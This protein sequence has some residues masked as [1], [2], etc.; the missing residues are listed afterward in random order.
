MSFF[1]LSIRRP[2]RSNRTFTL[3][4]YTTLCLSVPLVAVRLAVRATGFY[5]RSPV[6]VYYIGTGTKN[7][8]E[9]DSKGAR[10]AIGW[11]PSDR[12]T[13]DLVGQIQDTDTKGLALQDNVTG[14]FTPLYGKRKYSQFFDALSTNRY[15][16][17]SATGTYDV[18]IGR[19]IAVAAY[20]ESKLHTE[21]DFSATYVPLLPLFSLLGYNYPANTGFTYQST[22]PQK[23]KRSE[24]HTSELQSLMRISYAYFCLKKKTQT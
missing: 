10:L 3:F 6:F 18:G 13:I 20:S 22:I 9:S 2:P 15:R 8:N 19:V 11:T 17:L 23:K 1:F 21:N 12:V 24:E 7:D 14:T 5:R 16:L 4:P